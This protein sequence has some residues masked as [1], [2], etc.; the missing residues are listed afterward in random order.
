MY[1]IIT[2]PGSAHKDDFLA[3]SVL[4]AT[5]GDAE[6]HRRE[7]TR[8]DLDDP[9]TY[10]ID[11]GMEY[12][13]DKNNFDHH[14]DSTLPCAFHLV[15]QHLG[16]HEAAARVFVWYRYINMMDVRGPH[17]TADHLGIDAS[18]LFATSSPIEGYVL[19]H[20]AEV[21]TLDRND[22]VYKFML[23][24]G[25]DMIDLID[26]KMERLKRLKEEA[27]VFS[28]TRGKAVAS[29]IDHSPKLAMELYLDYLDDKD[30]VMTITPSSRGAGWELLRLGD[31]PKVDF[32]FIR[33]CPEIRFVHNNG[34]LAKTRERIPLS[35]VLP[36]AERAIKS[37]EQ[38]AEPAE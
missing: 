16:L 10:V 38:E 14:Q 30:I 6:V 11:V 23:A 4:L 36:L 19:S 7:P 27:Q 34:F 3:T 5:L 28:L 1:K 8:A 21:E 9:D 17:R 22:L 32:R 18:V 24:F 35:D 2:H 20:F 31:N 12:N 13:P 29:P 26:R 37:E 25:V 33:E 15:M